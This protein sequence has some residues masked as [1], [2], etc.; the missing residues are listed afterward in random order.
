M[1]S[2]KCFDVFPSSKI[3]PWKGYYKLKCIVSKNNSPSLHFLSAVDCTIKETM[4]FNNNPFSK[5]SNLSTIT[6][7]FISQGFTAHKCTEL[8]V[9]SFASCGEWSPI[10][11]RSVTVNIFKFQAQESNPFW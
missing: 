9:W 4:K 10:D 5:V 1:C 6:S 7:L 11:S 2:I 3:M 8:P